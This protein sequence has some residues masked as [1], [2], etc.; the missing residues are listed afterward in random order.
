MGGQHTTTATTRDRRLQW[1]RVQRFSI[2]ACGGRFT[3][4]LV[5]NVSGSGR[6][7]G[8]TIKTKKRRIEEIKCCVA[9]DPVGVDRRRR[10]RSFVC[11]S[12]RLQMSHRL[13]LARLSPLNPSTQT[14]THTH[15]IYIYNND[16]YFYVPFSYSPVLSIS[17]QLSLTWL[18]GCPAA[19]ASNQLLFPPDISG[20]ILFSL[21]SRS[22]YI[23]VRPVGPIS[24]IAP[25]FMNRYYNTLE[26]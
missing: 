10:V 23:T 18:A 20:E 1:R 4:H 22:S 19:A 26:R 2:G 8:R 7:R 13:F 6:W 3:V 21:L 14:H 5:P 17:L 9:K 15:I 11:L 12:R 25:L 16:V 24:Y